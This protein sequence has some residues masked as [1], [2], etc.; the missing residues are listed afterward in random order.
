MTNEIAGQ[1]ASANQSQAK[2]AAEGAT[3][4]NTKKTMGDYGN[5][6]K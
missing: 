4:Q 6:Q 5:A 3:G 2:S 1:N